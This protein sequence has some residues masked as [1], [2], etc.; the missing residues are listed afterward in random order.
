ME[1]EYT[2]QEESKEAEPAPVKSEGAQKEST[3]EVFEMYMRFQKDLE[4]IQMLSNPSYL[5]RERSFFSLA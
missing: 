4:F 2:K 1:I 3:A 5:S